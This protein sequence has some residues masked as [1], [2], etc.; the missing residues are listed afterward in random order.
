LTEQG[1]R[2]VA[3]RGR[4]DAAGRER[5]RTGAD[6]SGAVHGPFVT[7]SDLKE[8]FARFRKDQ[9]TD[10]AA[11]LTYYA[12]LSLFPALLFAV[13]LTGL[14]G[15][16]SLVTDAIQSLRDAGAPESTVNAVEQ[17]LRDAVS[18]DGA[19]TVAVAIGL[20]TALNGASGA[21]GAAGRALN[22]VFRVEEG[23][24]FVK[25]KLSDLGSTLIV[26]LSVLVTLFLIFSGGSLAGA[27]VGLVGLGD[28]AE[29]VWTYARWPAAM[30][31]AMVVYALVYALAPNVKVKRFQWVTP[32]AIVGVL[33]WLLASGLFFLYASH[34]TSYQAT[35]GA[36]A[37][38]VILLVWL[39]LTNVAMLLGAEI[40]AAV[41]TRRAPEF[42]KGYD[43]PPL[44]VKDAKD[45]E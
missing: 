27:V 32:G 9:M 25:R 3:E 41:D 20:L 19:A 12:L 34:A 21:F 40:N 38:L 30:V 17:P 23:R 22:V 13:A 35:Y 10:H 29:T 24:G 7:G 18:K 11:A 31:S 8:G 42:P 37:G 5:S 28:T 39:W 16:T 2:A 6:V 44:P 33:V 14:I 45:D 15:D 4:P 36:M 26:M 1:T 43:G